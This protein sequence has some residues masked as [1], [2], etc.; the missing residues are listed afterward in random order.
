MNLNNILSIVENKISSLNCDD[1][2]FLLSKEHEDLIRF[3][4][5]SINVF[6]NTENIAIEI[7]LGKDKKRASG[8]VYNLDETSI[9]NYL[10]SLFQYCNDSPMN[11]DYTHLPSGP[12]TYEINKHIDIDQINN[13]ESI[14]DHVENSINFALQYGASRVCGSFTSHIS[15]IILITSTGIESNDES[16]TNLLNIRAFTE[17]KSSGHGLSCSSSIDDIDSEKAGIDAGDYAKS[18]IN[19]KQCNPGKYDILFTP[20]VAADIFQFVGHAASADSVDSGDSFFANKI[21][22]KVSSDDLS[23]SDVGNPKNGIYQR[24]F[25]DEGIPTQSTKII[26]NGILTNYLHNITTSNK[27]GVKST[28]NAGIMAPFCWNIDV[29]SGNTTFEEQ[30]SSI[31]NGLLITN[32]WYTR[33]QNPAAGSYSTVPRDACFIIEN[34]KISSPIHGIR[35]SDDIPRQLLNI[36]SLSQTRKWINWWEVE[37]PVLSPSIVIKNVP[38]TRST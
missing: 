37:T 2:S 31:N 24:I 35:I 20:T 12:F 34:G 10:D 11:N 4:N 13:Y 17:S 33:F 38:V 7:Y 27:Y 36:D 19:P 9:I 32:N 26:D 5:N 3:S 18:S 22:F 25:D 6:D 29:S 21:N 14:I 8:V 30:L 15:E 1:Y 28:G 16:I 23:L